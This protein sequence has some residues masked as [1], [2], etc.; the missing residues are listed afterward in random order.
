VEAEYRLAD[1]L[2]RI[3]DS[4]VTGGQPE[5][6]RVGQVAQVGLAALG[7]EEDVSLPQMTRV[8]G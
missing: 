4:E 6:L 7:G 3:L 8:G 1:R 2:E 5:D